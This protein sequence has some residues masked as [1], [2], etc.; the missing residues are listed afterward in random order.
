MPVLAI[1]KRVGGVVVASAEAATRGD[2][3]GKFVCHA[4]GDNAHEIP[5]KTLSEAADYLRMNPRAGIRMNPG[6]SK[7]SRHIYIDGVPR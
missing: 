2:H 1:E 6:W 3:P 5:F 4:F 7:V